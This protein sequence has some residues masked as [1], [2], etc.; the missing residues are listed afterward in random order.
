MNT[1]GLS[2]Y[3]KRAG[4]IRSHL[5]MLFTES[6]QL[7][8]PELLGCV[9]RFEADI[10]SLKERGEISTPVVM[11]CGEKNVGKT[12]LCGLLTK[13]IRDTSTLGAWRREHN[14]NMHVDRSFRTNACVGCRFGGFA[15]Y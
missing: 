11:V 3:Q 7:E 13:K 14:K 10:L 2:L 8:L 12:H 1:D 6:T 15:G 9:D 5:E 4:N